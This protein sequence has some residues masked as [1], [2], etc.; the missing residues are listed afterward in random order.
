MAAVR[1]CHL[2]DLLVGVPFTASDIRGLERAWQ[3][4]E[5]FPPLSSDAADAPG[6]LYLFNGRCAGNSSAAALACERVQQQVEG[7]TRVGGRR[8][9]GRVVLAQAGLAGRS[10]A[11]DKLRSS[12]DWTMGPNNMFHRLLQQARRLG[13]GHLL[14]LEPDVLPIRAGWLDRAACLAAH[15]DA[16]VIGSALHANCS[17][18]GQTGACESELPERFAYHI[19]GNAIYAVGDPAFAAYAKAARN[20]PL[21]KLPFDLALHVLRDG[22]TQ[23][24]RRRLLHRFQHSSFV[25]NMGT[26]LPDVAALRESLPN[27]F[28]VHSSAYASLTDPELRALFLAGPAASGRPSADAATGLDVSALRAAAGAD[29]TAVVAFVAGVQYAPLCA[30][31]VAHA[32]RAAVRRLV[33]V[34]LDSPSLAMARESGL[35][36]VDATRL[37]SLP[38]GGSDAFGSAAFFAINGARYLALLQMLRAGFSLFVLDLDVVLLRDPLAWLAERGPAV[39]ELD[40]MIQ[41]DARDGVSTR[42]TDPGLVTSRLGLPPGTGW[43]YANGG[44]FFCRATPGT[45][46]LFDRV[47]S[48]LSAARTPPNEQDVLNRELAAAAALRW[49]LLPADAFPNGFVYFYRPLGAPEPPV[50]VHANWINGVRDKVYHLRE[51]GLWAVGDAPGVA[52]LLSVRDD[53][54]RHGRCDVASQLQALRDTLGLARMLNRTIV[55]PRLP[56]LRQRPSVRAATLAHF[57]DYASFAQHFPDHAP[58]FH[59]DTRRQGAARVHIEVGLDDAPPASLGFTAVGRGHP[60][61]LPPAEEELRRWLAPFES[62]SEIH[63]SS[64]HRRFGGFA[65]AREQND[66]SR[67]AARGLKLAPRLAT[68]SLEV[69]AALGR[70]PGGYDCVDATDSRD[71]AAV[72]LPPAGT[73]AGASDLLRGAATVLGASPRTV[74]VVGR[75]AGALAALGRTVRAVDLVPP[76]LVVDFDVVGSNGTEALAAVEM[77][78]CAHAQRFVG[79]LAA[80]STHRICRRRRTIDRRRASKA[81]ARGSQACQDAL[82]RTLAPGLARLLM[83]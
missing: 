49:G 15:S 12:A 54:E 83:E 22:R 31:F 72:L 17:R 16:W 76:W 78:V 56:L 48:R 11:Y 21:R 42:E 28:L 47:W 34:A 7:G 3:L 2:S 8:A 45:I 1:T 41:S 71:Y 14:Q 26:Q 51:A 73:R 75:P 58:R 63:I 33:L 77:E 24:A 50:L 80:A 68:V 13:Y 44:V 4:W 79:N 40:L 43:P 60:A 82:G 52:R 70:V 23:P 46:G 6:L 61:S 38:D 74:L 59:A 9:F 55:L 57:I 39:A 27:A 29:R 66:F 19:N 36:A 18:D 65:R 67:H 25:V 32:Q 5:H 53:C 10:D 30:N 37:V 20:G 35:P 69:R 81:P 64:A 62:A